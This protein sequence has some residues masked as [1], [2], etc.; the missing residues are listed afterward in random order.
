LTTTEALQSLH[1]EQQHYKL[2]EQQP[3]LFRIEQQFFVKVDMKALPLNSAACFIDA[4]ELLIKLFY[5]FNLSY[6]YDLKPVYGFFEHLMETPVT[7][8]R[9]SA[10]SDFLRQ[11]AL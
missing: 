9:S 6:P 1:D 10:L 2:T 5:V 8:G 3:Q 11:V 4:I 7:I